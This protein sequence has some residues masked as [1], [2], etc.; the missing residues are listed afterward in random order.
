MEWSLAVT[1]GQSFP[2]IILNFTLYF[3]LYFDNIWETIF[4]FY[5]NKKQ[6]L[7][8]PMF[9]NGQVIGQTLAG[10]R[11]KTKSKWIS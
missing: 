10:E 7:K 5:L 11:K 9:Y 3:L 6:G 4:L 8:Y 1:T 2:P